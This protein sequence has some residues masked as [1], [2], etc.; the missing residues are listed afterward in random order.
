MYWECRNYGGGAV[1][2]GVDGGSR[3]GGGCGCGG[4]VSGGGHGCIMRHIHH[5]ASDF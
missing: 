4:G 5:Y 3:G 1:G 2:G